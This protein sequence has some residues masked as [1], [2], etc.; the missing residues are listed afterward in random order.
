LALDAPAVFGAEKEGKH[1]L[2]RIGRAVITAGALLA[3][4]FAALPAVQASAAP[5]GPRAATV[6]VGASMVS[7]Q[8]CFK[9]TGF[10]AENA[11]LNFWQTNGGL[12]ILGYPVDVSRRYSDGFIRQF[13]QRAILEFHPENKAQYQVLLTRLGANLIDGSPRTADRPVPCNAGCTLFP[14]TNH[15]LRGVFSAYWN[16]YGGLP[17][18]GLPLT[19]EFQEINPSNGKIYT[20][21]YFERNRFEYHP[22]N[23]GR[24]QVLLGLL[25]SE[26]LAVVHDE[27]LQQPV[28]PTPNYGANATAPDVAA[29]PREGLVGTTFTFI[30]V[31][32]QPNTQYS[33][34]IA[35]DTSPAQRVDDGVFRSESDGTLTITFDSS[36]TPPGNYLIGAFDGNGRLVVAASFEIVFKAGG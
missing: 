33:I 27:V 20:V 24:Y 5:A 7:G 21:Q 15:T 8:V 12:E 25:G 2:R 16:A 22:E 13:Y 4:F 19:E 34:L 26:A 30:F 11:F 9:E 23:Q 28:A 36:R 35:T 17:V 6:P 31:G 14:E 10:C 29:L 18:F 1:L 3:V 32:L